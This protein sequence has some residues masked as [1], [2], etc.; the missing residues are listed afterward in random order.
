MITD[1]KEFIICNDDYYADAVSH[2]YDI[3]MEED[4]LF[5]WMEQYASQYKLQILTIRRMLLR[6][7]NKDSIIELI[8]KITR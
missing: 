4:D 8:D 6:G 1:P 7:A 5:K 3:R 2:G